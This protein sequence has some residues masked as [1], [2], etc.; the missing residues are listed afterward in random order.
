MKKQQSGFGILFDLVTPESHVKEGGNIHYGK[1]IEKAPLQTGGQYRGLSFSCTMDFWIS[2][3]VA[4]TG[5][6]LDLLFVYGL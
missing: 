5:V 4:D 3:D 6:Y 2:F 1:T